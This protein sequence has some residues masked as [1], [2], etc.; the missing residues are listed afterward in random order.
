MCVLRKRRCELL[1][2]FALAAPFVDVGRV[3][4]GGGG[5]SAIAAVITYGSAVHT[6]IRAPRSL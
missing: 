5:G 3:V 2:L 6:H 1:S 4:V